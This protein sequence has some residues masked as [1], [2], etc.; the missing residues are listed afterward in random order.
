[1]FVPYLLQKQSPKS[2]K[3]SLYLVRYKEDFRG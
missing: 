1:L 3:I 2:T